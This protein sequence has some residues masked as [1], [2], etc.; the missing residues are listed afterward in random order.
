M[1]VKQHSATMSATLHPVN[2][3]GSRAGGRSG[4]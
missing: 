3:G 1:I 4:V 2:R